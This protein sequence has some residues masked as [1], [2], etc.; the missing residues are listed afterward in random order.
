MK[1]IFGHDSESFVLDPQEYI[2]DK[3]LKR[4]PYDYSPLIK[5]KKLKC[6]TK[7][8]KIR[9]QIDDVERASKIMKERV[10]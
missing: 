1:L 6:R 5:S 8:I 4:L 2:K 3:D 7:I 9:N 10:R